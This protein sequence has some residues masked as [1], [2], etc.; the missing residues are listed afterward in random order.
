MPAHRDQSPGMF[1]NRVASIFVEAGSKSPARHS[2]QAG[3]RA[4][5]ASVI[6][7]EWHDIYIDQLFQPALCSEQPASCYSV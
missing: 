4:V 1:L 3:A 7:K 5:V 2:S 6:E